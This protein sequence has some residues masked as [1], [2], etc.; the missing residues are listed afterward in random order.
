MFELLLVCTTADVTF[1]VGDVVTLS[2][3]YEPT[4][5]RGVSV[6]ADATNVYIGIRS[7]PSL[8]AKNGSGANAITATSWRMVVR[9]YK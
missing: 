8:I 5:T 4:G 7:V 6:S 1:N 9:A 3:Y 2:S